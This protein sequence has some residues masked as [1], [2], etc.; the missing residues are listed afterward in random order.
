MPQESWIPRNTATPITL[1]NYRFHSNSYFLFLLFFFLHTTFFTF[2]TWQFSLFINF[3]AKAQNMVKYYW[4]NELSVG[5]LFWI[6]KVKEQRITIKN[7]MLL[8]FMALNFVYRK[9]GNVYQVRTFLQKFHCLCFLTN[10]NY[11]YSQL[12]DF[13][14]FL[15]FYC[16]IGISFTT[17]KLKWKKN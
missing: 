17:N 16:W 9:I 4:R 10:Q 11:I 2:S 3:T 6:Q 13:L 15:F 5:N 12:Y 14:E 8:I 1:Q 7:C